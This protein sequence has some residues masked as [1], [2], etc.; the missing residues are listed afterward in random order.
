MQVQQPGGGIILLSFIVAFLLT[1]IPLP[2]WVDRFRPDWLGLVLIYWCM[3][4]PQRVGIGTGWLMGLFLDAAQGTLLGQHALALAVVA[5]LT[6]K[7]YRRIRV[8]PLWQQSFSVLVFLGLN[9]LLVF[10]INGVIGYPPRDFWYLGPALGGMLFWPW[11]FVILRD[12]R[13]RF[14][15]A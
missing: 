2:L 1:I 4:V 11:V 6:L 13:R 12:L 5:F 14:H 10:W 15:I 3:A 9:Q 7:T 8:L